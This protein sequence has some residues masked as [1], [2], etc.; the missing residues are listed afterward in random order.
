MAH[1]LFE[2][3]PTPLGEKLWRR[4]REFNLGLPAKEPQETSLPAQTDI[5]GTTQAEQLDARGR[6]HFL[7]AALTADPIKK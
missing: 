5:V 4:V 3:T 7:L 2:P 1:S 6:Q